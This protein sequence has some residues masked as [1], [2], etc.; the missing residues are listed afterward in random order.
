[1]MT[2]SLHV[3]QPMLHAQGAA[4]ATHPHPCV[5]WLR[6]PHLLTASLQS[7]QASSNS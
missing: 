5:L 4:L 1:M 7:D 6:A 3:I 2:V